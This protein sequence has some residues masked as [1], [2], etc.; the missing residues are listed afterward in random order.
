M[1]RSEKWTLALVVKGEYLDCAMHYFVAFMTIK[2]AFCL[3]LLV[4]NGILKPTA[5]FVQGAVKLRN[6]SKHGI[7][8]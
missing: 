5:R 4:H 7:A 6:F 1:A 3:S 8:E 2:V